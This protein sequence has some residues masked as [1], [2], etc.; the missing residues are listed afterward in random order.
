MTAQQLER[1][2]ELAA[3]AYDF[4]RCSKPAVARRFHDAAQTASL[5]AV[6][7]AKQEERASLQAQITDFRAALDGPAVA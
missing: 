4:Y 1:L 7:L 5:L 6:E 2:S 3:F